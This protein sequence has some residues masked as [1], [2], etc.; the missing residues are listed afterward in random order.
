M[1]VGLL[2]LRRSGGGMFGLTPIL[3]RQVRWRLWLAVILSIY[4]NRVLS[5]LKAVIWLSLAIVAETPP[6][7]SPATWLFIPCLFIPLYVLGD[8]SFQYEW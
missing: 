3:M 7:V 5:F 6:A 4:L 1:L 8:S 2:L